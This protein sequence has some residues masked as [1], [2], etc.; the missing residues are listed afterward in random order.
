MTENNN[1]Y[2]AAGFIKR[3]AALIYDALIVAALLILASAIGMGIA[4][5]ILGSDAVTE[6]K[7]LEENPAFFGWLI[8]CWFYYYYYCWVKT[9]Q[10]LAM[11]TWRL[12]L[13]TISG[14]PIEMHQAL[15]RFFLG[16]FGLGIVTTIFP[17]HWALHEHLSRTRVIILPKGS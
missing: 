8:F 10:T 5:L 14:A 7:V 4:V 17:G 9:G 13:V 6:Q 2:E 15:I 16:F 3:F 11:K 12:K 1:N